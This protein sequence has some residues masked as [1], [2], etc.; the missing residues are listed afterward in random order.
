[1]LRPLPLLLLLS[2]ALPAEEKLDPARYVTV[3]KGDL[4][5]ILSAPHGGRL[6]VPGVAERKG[7]G[8][9]QFTTV[10]EENTAE[11]ALALAAILEQVFGAR[12]HVVVAHFERK[13]LDA[14]RPAAS[15][16][17]GKEAA[18]LYDAYHAALDAACKQV[19]KDF[20]RGLLLDL[21]GQA[22]DADA[23]YR[24]TVNGKSV[25]LLVQRF[26][27]AAVTGEKSVLGALAKLGYKVLP[28]NDAA[29]QKETKFNG[30]HIVRTYGSH[31][32]SGIDA[33]QLELGSALRSKKGQETLIPDL[34][35][36]LE[37]FAKAYLPAKKVVR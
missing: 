4:P 32:G 33:I 12:P 7:E 10:R 34:V 8:I 18:P 20:G 25:T 15:A 11:I 37:V 35:A 28:A 16:Y 21:H 27:Q 36:A 1:M 30:G 14:N 26:G 3:I 29:D 5:I 19:Q 9:A 6:K 13:Y 23:I 24:G 2:S 17:E 31:G 22:G